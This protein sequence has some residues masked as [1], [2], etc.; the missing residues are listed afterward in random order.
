MY[1][2]LG[3]IEDSLPDGAIFVLARPEDRNELQTDTSITVWNF[4]HETQA[5]VKVRG[6]VTEV[7]GF[8]ASFRTDQI[9]QQPG[10]PEHLDPIGAGNPVYRAHPGTF[11]P[12]GS[13]NASYDE[14]QDMWERAYE[15][16]EATGIRPA[17]PASLPPDHPARNP[18][19]ETFTDHC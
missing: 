18:P 13:R 4:W 16:Q 15:H 9:D 1:M 6:T 19:A 2:P 3:Y 10:W 7:T 17:G 5:L 14:L 8:R 11:D 12:D